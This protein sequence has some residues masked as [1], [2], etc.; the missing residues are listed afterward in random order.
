[1]VAGEEKLYL[2]QRKTNNQSSQDLQIP[3]G[4]QHFSRFHRRK[5]Y[6]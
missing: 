5:S 1:M 2:L 4:R 6:P 3:F